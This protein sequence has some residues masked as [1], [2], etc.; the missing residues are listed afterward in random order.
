MMTSPSRGSHALEFGMPQLMPVI[1]VQ[2]PRAED[3]TVEKC[4]I[5]A[6]SK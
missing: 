4:Q 3:V 6:D 1:W 5:P 2:L